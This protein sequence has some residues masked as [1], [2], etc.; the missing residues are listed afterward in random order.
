MSLG[1]I[2][3]FTGIKDIES[4]NGVVKFVLN[5]EIGET[6]PPT[7]EGTLVQVAARCFVI[8]SSE[9]EIY[10]IEK[11]VYEVFKVEDNTGHNLLI[12]K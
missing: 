2:S 12:Y 10:E 3:N 11:K 6:I 7:A 1:S 8:V 5:H 9:R 4:I